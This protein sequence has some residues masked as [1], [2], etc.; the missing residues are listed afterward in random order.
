VG[1]RDTSIHNIRRKKK[2]QLPRLEAI[3][4]QWKTILILALA[5]A[6]TFSIGTYANQVKVQQTSSI[7]GNHQQVPAPELQIVNNFWR[8]DVNQSLVTHVVLVVTTTGASPVVNKLYQIVVQVSCLSPAGIVY[9]CS[10]GTTVIVLPSN[11][12]GSNAVVVVPLQTPIEPETTE[13]DDIS[14]IVTDTVIPTTTPG[15][16][17]L[18]PNATPTL[19]SSGTGTLQATLTSIN[20]FVGT[21]QFG[22][23]SNDPTVSVSLNPQPLPP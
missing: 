20:G 12:G 17:A 4:A 22:I 19:S 9:T 3:K 23:A 7:G 18:T 10:A 11:T 13:I 2:I 8:I 1:R 16:I 6:T 15:V 5:C 21:V 14:Y